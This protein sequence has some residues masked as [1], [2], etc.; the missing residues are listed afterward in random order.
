MDGLTPCTPPPNYRKACYI[1]FPPK[2]PPRFIRAIVYVFVHPGIDCPAP[3]YNLLHCTAL[4]I[5]SSCAFPCVLATAWILAD[6]R[7]SASLRSL[8]HPSSTRTNFFSAALRVADR[9]DKDA[10]R[11]DSFGARRDSREGGRRRG[12]LNGIIQYLLNSV[13]YINVL[14]IVVGPVL[15]SYVNLS[16]AR[17]MIVILQTE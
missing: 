17:G 2:Y 11:V 15:V 10:S 9:A 1:Q 12:V 6:I 4:F 16:A 5:T 14:E 8:E 13:E 7:R 3:H